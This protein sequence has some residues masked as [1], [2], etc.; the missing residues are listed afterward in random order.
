MPESNRSRVVRVATSNRKKFE[1]IRL[2]L[3]S[4]GLRAVRTRGKD[5]EIQHDDV[6]VVA[7]RAL[8]EALKHRSEALLIEDAGLYVEALKGFPG[9]YSS[10]VFRTIG[11]NGLLRLL[12]GEKRREAEFRSAVAYGE[13]DGSIW[14][15]EGPVRG[16]IA[17]N[18]RGT[19][20]FGFDPIFI[21][22]SFTH[23]FAEMPIEKKNRISHRALAVT[24]FAKWYTTRIG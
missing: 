21:P 11:G 24:A 10:Y 19:R 7:E 9:A 18:P 6:R 5:V 14:L 2:L 13:T 22:E 1:E 4:Y 16:T 20:G 15:F 3:D 12:S 8:K 17:K 23:T